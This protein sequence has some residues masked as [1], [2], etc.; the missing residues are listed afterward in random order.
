MSIYSAEERKPRQ[1]RM[2]SFTEWVW[3]VTVLVPHEM[4]I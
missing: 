1:R 3:H 4:P 2:T